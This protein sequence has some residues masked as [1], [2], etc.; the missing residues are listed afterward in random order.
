MLKLPPLS[1]YIH[2]PWC[3][4]KCPYCDFHSQP[5]KGRLPNIKYINHLLHDLEQDLQHISNNREV[6]SIYIGGG[7]P[8]LLSNNAIQMLMDGIRTRLLLNENS[9]ITIEINPEIIDS[10][11]FI[12][13]QK[14]GINRISIGVQSFNSKKLKSLGRTHSSKKA[15]EIINL[16][17]KMNF[18]SF[19]IDLMYGLPN[20]S[21]EEAIHD[22]CQAIVLNPP[23][24]SWYQLT[25]EANTLF[26][27]Y[28]PSLPDD[29]TL[30]NI[31]KKGNQL[32]TAAGYHRY[33]ISA[34]AKPGYYC[35]HNLNY[36][37]FGDY[38]GIGCSAHGKLTKPNGC[39]IRIVKNKYLYSF[40][41]GKYIDTQ[42]QLNND[43]KKIEFLMNRFRLF[44][45]IPC[46]DFYKYTGLHETVIESQ[47]K[48]AIA[49]G[50]LL[51]VKNYWKVT[52]K[53]K[54]FLNSLLELFL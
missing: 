41:N 39:I 21:L 8:S 49:S 7:T 51:K 54:L 34:Y 44:E 37:R 29:T 15:K 2:I 48:N 47:I 38:L 45:N 13:Y 4:Q 1:L 18:K 3:I 30:W 17:S 24:L 40:M 11:R 25:I 42:Y 6:I 27:S 43:D 28:Q 10:N 33:E 53:G 22:L 5:L 19:N 23:H 12:K 16:V 52:K 46:S 14:T 31:Y 26:N 50:Y 32:L 20:Q 9:E 35:K 36:W